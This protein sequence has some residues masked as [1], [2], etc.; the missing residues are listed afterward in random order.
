MAR[1][2]EHHASGPRQHAPHS[3]GQ[4]TPPNS[5]P[6][7]SISCG[8]HHCCAIKQSNGI[9]LAAFVT[10]VFPLAAPGKLVI[11]EVPRSEFATS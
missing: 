9:E 8:V 2:A 11:L 3:V 1:H 7:E 6:Y 10:D 5:A 4:S